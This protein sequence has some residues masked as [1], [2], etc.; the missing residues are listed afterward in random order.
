[1]ETRG[2]L[3]RVSVRGILI[4]VHNEIVCTQVEPSTRCSDQSRV[5]SSTT[6]ASK[7]EKASSESVRARAPTTVEYGN[8]LEQTRRRR[9]QGHRPPPDTRTG[10]RAFNALVAFPPN[11]QVTG[12]VIGNR[13]P[14]RYSFCSLTHQTTQ[15]MCWVF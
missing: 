13:H 5:Q 14:S 7:M 4:D 6:A 1:M 11:R 15:S 2:L 9:A 12:S 3:S 8:K 10:T